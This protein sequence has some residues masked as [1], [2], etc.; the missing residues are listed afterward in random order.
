[1]LKK[2]ALNGLKVVEFGMA[3]VGPLLTKWLAACG[4]TVVR[5]E[6][7]KK[8]DILRVAS[9]YAKGVPGI[10]RAIYYIYN[11]G[12]YSLGL[13]LDKPQGIEIA[14]KLVA[15]ADVVVENFAANT[16]DKWG[17]GYDELKRIRNNIIVVRASAYGQTGP[18]SK[19]KGFGGQ[20]AALAGLTHLIGW[21]GRGPVGSPNAYTDFVAAW[22]GIIATMSALSYRQRTGKGVYIDLSQVESGVTVITPAMLDYM[23]NQRIQNAAGN[24]CAYAAPHGAYRCRGDDRWCVI[25]VFG[26]EDWAAFCKAIGRPAWVSDSKF[27]TA[28]ARKRNEDELD[29]LVEQWTVQ[30]TAEEITEVMQ[31]A[32]VAAGT[33]KSA[34]DLFNDP[35][36]KHRSHFW[37]LEHPE[38]GTVSYEAPSFRLSATPIEINQGAPLFAEHTEYVCKHLLGISDE[39]FDR[40][41]ISDAVSLPVQS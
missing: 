20:L 8:I 13:N 21:P 6:S 5:I 16:L 37:P 39:E 25:A 29:R 33:V 4:A 24:R 7:E 32:G 30:H 2:Q 41:L 26:E 35:Q 10:N 12:K 23:V 22:Y 3:I 27:G 34:E 36:L 14:K 40:L 1:M 31:Q 11:D 28:V 38:M 18:Y 19:Q 17:L 15:W 9:P